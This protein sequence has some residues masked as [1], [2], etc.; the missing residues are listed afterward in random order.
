MSGS[1][2]F[3]LAHDRVVQAG[4]G[5]G[6]THA[7]LTQYLHL[8]AGVTA[9]RRA[10]PPSQICALTFTEK[11]AAEMRER[12][13]SRVT[14]ICRR[15]AEENPE[16]PAAALRDSEPALVESAERLGVK[17]P[18]ASAWEQVL[19]SLGG[20]TISTFHSFAASLLR[21][22]SQQVGLDPEFSLLDEDGAAQRLRDTC[23]ELVLSALEQPASVVDGPEFGETMEALLTEL[24]F[25]S[26]GGGD[27]GL[28]EVLCLLHRQRA[29]EGRPIEG[30][31]AA[32]RPE[33]LAVELTQARDR[34]S[35]VLHHL[36][37]RA[38]E[39][40]DKSAERAT[41]LGGLAVRVVNQLHS[42]DDLAGCRPV[43][44]Q[45]RDCLKLLR[46][47]SGAK[48]DPSLVQSIKAWRQQTYEALDDLKALAVSQRAA[49]LANGLEL[50]LGPLA[51]RFASGKQEES[52]L[53]FS[54]LL[55]LS[56]DLLRDHPTVRDEL[57]RRFQVFLVDEFQDTSPLQAE[58]LTLLV[59]DEA[60]TPG[61]LYIVGDRK[62]SIYDF[63]GADVAAF[64]RLC[65]RLTELGADEETLD[66]SYRSLP[67][68]LSFVNTLFAKVMQPP[69]DD[70]PD[71]FV[72]WNPACDPLTAQ[73]STAT[74]HPQVEL[75]RA[76]ELPVDSPSPK[77]AS[78]KPAAIVREAEL[79]GQRITALID[80]GTRP[81]DIVVLLRRFTHLL[82]YTTALRRR[83]IPHYVVR[84]RGF[85]AAQEVLD[86]A[87]LLRLIDDPTDLLSLVAVLRSPLIGLSDESL[88]RLHLAGKLSL[89]ALHQLT[90]PY[91]D[92]PIPSEEPIDLP[93][94]LPSDL[95]PDDLQLRLPADEMTRLQRFATL[96]KLLATE[97]DRLDPAQLLT[98]VLDHC[99]YLAV[100][101][102]DRDGE[103]RLA[104]VERL[105][106][107][108]RSYAGR[109]RA[110]VRFLRLQTDPELFR[111]SGDPSD[112]PA[113]QLLS[114][115]DNVVRIMTVHQAKG[116][117]FPTVIVA[118]CTTR[119]RN[120]LPQ[121][122]YDRELGLGLS[123]YEDGERCQSLPQRRIHVSRKLR[124]Q[125]ESA[126]LFYVAATRAKDRLIWLGESDRS[127]TGSWRQA[128]EQ[129][130]ATPTGPK[131]LTEWQPSLTAPLREHPSDATTAQ[132]GSAQAEQ[133][134]RLVYDPP[135]PAPQNTP[136]LTAQ[137]AELLACGRRHHLLTTIPGMLSR[138]DGRARTS[139]ETMGLSPLGCLVAGTLPQRLWA[140]VERPTPA[141]L[142]RTLTGL[143]ILR[144]NPPAQEALTWLGLLL[145]SR[146]FHTELLEPGL[147]PS[148][149]RGVRYHVPVGPQKLH[150]VLDLWWQRRDGTVCV[151]D[152]QL[153]SPPQNEHA[154]HTARRALLG[155]V[156]L[157]LAAPNTTEVWVGVLYLQDAE[158]SPRFARL[159]WSE[160][161]AALSPLAELPSL[162]LP[163][164]AVFGLVEQP[165][166]I[167]IQLSCEF[168]GF[169]HGT[170][171]YI[172]P[173]AD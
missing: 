136:M 139:D 19:A 103:Q 64:T 84:G 88:A 57:R 47:P 7:L 45:I 10:I 98:L 81:G 123:L 162:P 20:A 6:K 22:Y 146:W 80:E 173:H 58:L 97:A 73:R 150:G 43:F 161:A 157:Q 78:P 59:G 50:L 133:L 68:V 155:H 77:P 96:H 70:S 115:S 56:R 1:D 117:E 170:S 61:R 52:V 42:L 75:L 66:R 63:R 159:G 5:T 145:K 165:L 94:D 118:G 33:R 62:Q 34:L 141:D 55:R 35:T 36:A 21:R 125:A 104:N 131:L 14:K 67:T 53:D 134:V 99:D 102:A 122:V 16:S 113:A 30:I 168:R 124:A 142:E 143:G 32:Y 137:A 138:P 71:W 24:G 130:L 116:L 37:S 65:Q 4:A 17:L 39:L 128:L 120:D 82:H 48:A 83:R 72:R 26:S 101:A 169:C 15:L 158:P 93:I 74:S 86:L 54:D 126:R 27:G 114:E 49:R 51:R 148:L 38:D 171:D 100:L 109:L 132:L 172:A 164:H 31:A 87:S 160:I 153:A 28:V 111:T 149:R 76:V 108:A 110:F 95:L 147:W 135:R 18:D 40:A 163:A 23:E 90:D 85:F 41:I 89:S 107:R 13:T 29:E 152:L 8:V 166:S 129:L 91:T 112:E 9:Y 121:V 12:L 144:E 44:E 105:L 2:R 69:S 156:A 140:L 11:A 3:L 119:E 154:W 60:H 127:A 25:A 151:V 106:A 79:L 92:P 167:C 46:A